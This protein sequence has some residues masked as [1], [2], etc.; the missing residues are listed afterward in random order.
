[1]EIR[2]PAPVCDAKRELELG[3]SSTQIVNESNALNV[4]VDQEKKKR[5]IWQGDG[6]KEGWALEGGK[7][8]TLGF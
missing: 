3:D 4:T 5:N 6:G 8:K 1:M 7:V 2:F